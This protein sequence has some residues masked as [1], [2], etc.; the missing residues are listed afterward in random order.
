M[1]RP[2]SFQPLARPE[3]ARSDDT[4]RQIRFPALPS[5][6]NNRSAQSAV[7]RPPTR[8]LIC[9]AAHA[10]NPGED[11]L[12]GGSPSQNAVWAEVLLPWIMTRPPKHVQYADIGC[13]GGE[14]GEEL[15]AISHP[16]S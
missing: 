13:E 3:I 14:G 11:P 4:R 2:G 7:N 9:R 8:F 16:W 15:L 5:A 1:L 6:A 12:N 10:S